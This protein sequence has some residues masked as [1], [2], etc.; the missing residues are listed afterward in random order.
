MD[1]LIST[2]FYAV[3][4]A[5]VC[6]AVYRRGLNDGRAEAEKRAAEL[7]ERQNRRFSGGYDEP[8]NL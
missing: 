3:V 1:I 6:V 5:T 7:A 4:W 8:S 2:F